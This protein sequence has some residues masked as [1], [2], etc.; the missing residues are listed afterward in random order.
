MYFGMVI[1][2][3]LHGLILLPVLLSFVGPYR[4]V[5]RS[6]M[7]DRTANPSGSVQL[8]DMVGEDQERQ[9]LTGKHTA[10]I[11]NIPKATSSSNISSGTPSKKIIFTNNQMRKSP[12]KGS[13][14]SLNHNS[15][16][17]EDLNRKNTPLRHS[18]TP[19]L[20]SIHSNTPSRQS[21]AKT[22][23]ELEELEQ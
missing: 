12:K 1:I 13:H 3:A 21:L 23:E 6:N 7:P 9:C 19:S 22:A 20:H 4:K 8:E 10:S 18:N 17:V 5:V 16:E 2:G 14:M 15:E 11:N